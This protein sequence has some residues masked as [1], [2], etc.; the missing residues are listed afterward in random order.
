MQS[1]APGGAVSSLKPVSLPQGL[2]SSGLWVPSLAA[3]EAAGLL[4]KSDLRLLR[5]SRSVLGRGR[6]P[7]T[8]QGSSLE[9]Q[10]E[11]ITAARTESMDFEPNPAPL[12]QLASLSQPS[13]RRP[14][15]KRESQNNPATS[16]LFFES[17]KT[18]LDWLQAVCLPQPSLAPGGWACWPE[19]APA[20]PVPVGVPPGPGNTLSCGS[21]DPRLSSVQPEAPCIAENGFT[22]AALR[23]ASLVSSRM[24]RCP[25]TTP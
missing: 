21:L 20:L 25:H 14:G 15:S 8:P 1:K 7:Q 6:G 5:G 12:K 24:S 3:Q 19:S 17:Q 10:T 11:A 23:V 13:F 18:P 22:G 16:F 4:V 2:P 9:G